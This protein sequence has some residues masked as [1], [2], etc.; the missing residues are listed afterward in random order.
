M[1]DRLK[2]QLL[3]VRLII[4]RRLVEPLMEK[5]CKLWYK[6]QIW[7]GDT[8]KY[9]KQIYPTSHLKIEAGGQFEFQIEIQIHVR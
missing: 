3:I 2:H 5:S 8:M 7:H 4:V 6:Q 1:F 9:T